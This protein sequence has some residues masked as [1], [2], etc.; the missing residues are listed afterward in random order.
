MD[1]VVDREGEEHTNELEAKGKLK[2]ITIEPIKPT[3]VFRE[4]H[5]KIRV[6]YC[7]SNQLEILILDTT[8]ISPFFTDKLNT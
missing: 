3:I 5:I 7:F 8:L 2:R 1:G 6:K 4:E